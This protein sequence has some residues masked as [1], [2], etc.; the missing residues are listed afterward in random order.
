[1]ISKMSN[2]MGVVVPAPEEATDTERESEEGPK[3][4][5]VAI[6]EDATMELVMESLAP[7]S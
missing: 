1:M 7:V 4:A 5:L 3:L 2:I 6:S